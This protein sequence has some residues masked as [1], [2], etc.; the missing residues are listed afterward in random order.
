MN[1][2]HPPLDMIIETRTGRRYIAWTDA[3]FGLMYNME[4]RVPAGVIGVVNAWYKTNKDNIPWGERV[5]Y[6]RDGF[7]TCHKPTQ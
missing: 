5:A 3:E 6:S 1:S 4:N 7:L 2:D